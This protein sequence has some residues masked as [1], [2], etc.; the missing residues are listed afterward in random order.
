[1]KNKFYIETQLAVETELE[2]L[3]KLPPKEYGVL[4]DAMS[5]SVLGGGKRLRGVMMLECGR[6]CGLSREEILPFACAI[7]IIHS[8]TLIHDDLPCM[9]NDDF[10]RGKPACHKA[11][12][13]DVALLAGDAL[14]AYALHRLLMDVGK[15][16]YAGNITDAIAVFTSLCGADGVFG[17]QILD[18][19]FE[20]EP[21]NFEQLLQLHSLKT[22]ALFLSC[23]RIPCI[24][25]RADA[26]T[27]KALR[28]Y[29]SKLGL[30]FQVKDDLLDLEGSFDT[31]GKAIGADSEKSTFVTLL[32]AEESKNYLKKLVLEAREAI[33][34]LPD[35]ELLLW[36]SE[37]VMNRNV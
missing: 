24:L 33:S 35:N 12:G 17:G 36:I 26:K 11:F 4:F 28:T 30:A 6:L 10:R 2:N 21:C 23:A 5:Y 37:F 34:V 27:E 15:F 19:R 13:E 29:M 8:S 9:D 7:E 20:T 1:M 32:G 22:G 25:S 18:K 31:L 16:E 3:F 14:Y